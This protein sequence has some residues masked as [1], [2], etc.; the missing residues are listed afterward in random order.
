VIVN[1]ARLR[2]EIVG[3]REFLLREPKQVLRGGKAW[4]TRPQAN[5]CAG[6]NAGELRIELQRETDGARGIQGQLDLVPRTIEEIT[7]CSKV[8][9]P[10]RERLIGK[11]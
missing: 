1:I 8:Q 11:D 3:W 6:T 4:E 9:L 5:L 10:E 7:A 2:R